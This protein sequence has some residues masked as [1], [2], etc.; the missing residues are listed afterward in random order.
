[1]KIS[2]VVASS[3]KQPG[4]A[5][6]DN[7]LTRNGTE[8]IPSVSHVFSKNQHLYLFFE[9]YDPKHPDDVDVG[10]KTAAR[11]LTNATF[12]RNDSKVFE[13]PLVEVNQINTPDR[14]A[15]AVEL[16][17]PLADFKAGFYTCQVNVIDDAAG[18]FVFP[19]L[20]LLVR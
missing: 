4:K 16:D 10:N 20:S 2:S 14:K 8:L 3:Q 1:M 9:I 11:L 6:K 13:T 7:P 19:R 18:Q 15:A 17:I 12:F 5:K